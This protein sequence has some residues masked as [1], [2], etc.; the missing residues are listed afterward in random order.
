MDRASERVQAGA[1]LGAAVLAVG[2]VLPLSAP[3]AS[4][5]ADA[6]GLFA[7]G[8]ACGPSETLVGT[9]GLLARIRADASS[10]RRLGAARGR[11]RGAQGSAATRRRPGAPQVEPEPRAAALRSFYTCNAAPI[12]NFAE[13]TGWRL[14]GP[15]RHS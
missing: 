4:A 10:P 14:V 11:P 7:P 15:L 9:G 3:A 2:T 8:S 1:L 12:P 6:L 13:G 5:S